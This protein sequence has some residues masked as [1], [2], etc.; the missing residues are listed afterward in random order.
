M[1]KDYI[2]RYVNNELGDSELASPMEPPDAFAPSDVPQVPME[3]LAKPLRELMEEHEQYQKILNVFENAL[4]ELKK[5]DWKFNPEI[6]AGLKSFFQFFDQETGY[7]NKKEEKALFPILREKF[8]AS[9]E[10]NPSGNQTPIEVM[11]DE[12][13]QVSQSVAIVFNFLGISARLPDPKSRILILEHALQ[14]GQEIVETM[15]LHIHKENTVI[16]PLAHQL[17]TPKEFLAIEG[18]IQTL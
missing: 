3:E 7:H 9:G 10:H 1:E 6:S 13:Q 18:R 17:L 14:L 15:N 16:F 5:Q 11:E 2:K 4:L 8:L 12:H